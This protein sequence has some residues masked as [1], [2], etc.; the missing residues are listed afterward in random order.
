MAESSAAAAIL[1]A[2]RWQAFIRGR[3]GA[4]ETDICNSI[5]I[6]VLLHFS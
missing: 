2:A 4:K 3:G 1:I 5:V 6:I